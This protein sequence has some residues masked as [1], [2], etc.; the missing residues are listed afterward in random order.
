[1]L[2]NASSGVHPKS[3]VGFAFILCISCLI[4][5]NK[6]K[7]IHLA[8]ITTVWPAKWTFLLHSTDLWLHLDFF[9]A[10]WLI[11]PQKYF[12]KKITNQ[13]KP[14]NHRHVVFFHYERRRKKVPNLYTDQPQLLYSMCITFKS[15]LLAATCAQLTSPQHTLFISVWNRWHSY[16]D[17]CL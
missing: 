1:M 14:I 2:H 7:T 17:W 9:L 4:S 3:L 16:R 13:N 12:F 8:V 6:K 5:V 11:L 10:W 15:C